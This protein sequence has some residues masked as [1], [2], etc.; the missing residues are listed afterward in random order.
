MAMSCENLSKILF[1]I[2]VMI[3]EVKFVRTA[4]RTPTSEE[5]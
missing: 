4:A 3:A 2:M 5:A 1:A